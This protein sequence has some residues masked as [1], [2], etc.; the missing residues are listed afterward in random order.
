MLLKLK[1][2]SEVVLLIYVLVTV[3]RNYC[4]Q[5]VTAEPEL[6]FLFGA[7]FLFLHNWRRRV[8]T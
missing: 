3:K 6:A 8:D 7:W 1:Y 2:G 4:S 5:A